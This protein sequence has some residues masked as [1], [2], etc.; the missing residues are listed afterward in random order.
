MC[1]FSKRI[2][3]ISAKRHIDHGHVT[4]DSVI[5]TKHKVR[6]AFEIT[7]FITLGF[8]DNDI[9]LRR[10][11]HNTVSVHGCGDDTCHRRSVTLLILDQ[12]PIIGAVFKHIILDDLVLGG[13]VGILADT[14][15]ELRVIGVDTRIDH[16]NRD[17]RTLCLVPDVAHV[18][19]VQ[20]G[21]SVVVDIAHGILWAGGKPL[22]ACFFFAIIARQ[23]IADLC[24][25]V[26]R[27][28]LDILTVLLV[29][30]NIE[31]RDPFGQGQCREATV[32]GDTKLRSKGLGQLLRPRLR[33][34]RQHDALRIIASLVII[35][36]LQSLI[37][38]F[39]QHFFVSM[40]H[41]QCDGAYNQAEDQNADQNNP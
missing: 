13:V 41:Q 26:Q 36:L 9:H 8:D 16:R 30:V 10:D 6:G 40:K 24:L 12:R 5:Q 23:K 34:V 37:L 38:L 21:L 14:P 20:I 33:G 4:F 32:L 27:H 39:L 1:R 28:I 18:E 15:R 3:T 35:K 11:T 29:L 22:A 7:I 31:N 19:V 25:I 17:T 2:D